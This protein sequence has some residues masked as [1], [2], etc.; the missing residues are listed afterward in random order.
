MEGIAHDGDGRGGVNALVQFRYRIALVLL[1]VCGL[2][3]AG[4]YWLHV[5]R[6]V[7]PSDLVSYLPATNASVIY[8]DVDALRRAGF[9]SMLAGSKTAEEPDYQ[10]FVQAT[11]FDY[12]HDLDA[13]AAA[14]K[15]GRIYFAL[16][17]RFH[18][19]N[20]RDYAARDG[21]SC[22]NDF[23][24]MPGSQ[25]NRRISFYLLKP[26]VMAM[27]IGPDDFAA[28]Q[29][30]SKSSQFVLA[31]PREPVWALIPAAALKDVDSLPVAAKAYVPALRGADQ[32]VF[33]IAA[34]ASQQLQFGLHVTCKGAPEATALV[35]Q[36]EGITKAL[37]DLLARQRQKPD[38]S[39]LSGVLVAGSFRRDERQVYGAWPIP[40]A[41]VDAIAGAY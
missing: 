1:V 13:V 11:K 37:R 25:P 26:D 14:L 23:C 18:W 9:L 22:H 33:S 30:T 29:V 24:V 32:I 27:A 3:G 40:K 39:D 35:T 31:V 41:F 16:R 5:R 34:D 28:Y 2:A 19:S 15:D 36:F 17:G 8:I 6:A 10:Q 20:L 21:G 4:I 38:P 7:R 12:A